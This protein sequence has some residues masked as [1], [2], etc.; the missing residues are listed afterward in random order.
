KA[1]TGVYA[2]EDGSSRTF[3]WEDGHLWSQRSGSNKFKVEPIADDHFVYEGSLSSIRFI[4][5]GDAM[6]AVFTNGNTST[7]GRRTDAEAPAG[8]TEISLTPDQLAPLLGVYEIQPGFDIA[9]TL[10]D[11]K[12]MTQAT[13][14]PAFE[15][16]AESPTRFFLKVVEAQ[17]EFIADD[18]GAYSSIML[19]QGGQSIPGKRKP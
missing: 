13:G 7:P 5:D 1:Y 18:T 11:G 8:R 19:Y 15:V 10:K 14:Q 6:T 16:Y 12:L 9:F 4:R 2:F 17:I 3:T